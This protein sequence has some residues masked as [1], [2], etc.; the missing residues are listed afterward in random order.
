MIARTTAARIAEPGQP[1]RSGTGNPSVTRAI[2]AIATAEARNCAALSVIT[3]W[4]GRIRACRT[5]KAEPIST[6]SSTS[7]SPAADAPPPPAPATTA[8]PA[9]ARPKPSQAASLT[10]AP[11]KSTA[12]TATITGTAPISSAAWVTLVLVRP[13]F[14]T[15][16]QPP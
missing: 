4:P 15:A 8:I 10:R 13:R 6:D 2:G 16:M 11:S 12:R 1:V 14:W 3:S 7:A 5:V 9:R